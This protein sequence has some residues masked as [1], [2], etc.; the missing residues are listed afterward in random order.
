MSNA[1][2]PHDDCPVPQIEAIGDLDVSCLV[3]D[4]PFPCLGIPPI[5]P[6]FS[7]DF[8]CYPLDI[9]VDWD[10]KPS[11]EPD[12]SVRVS[13][14][15]KDQTGYCRPQIRFRVRMGAAGCGNIAVMVLADYNVV[16]S[17]CQTIDG[18][19]VCEDDRVITIAQTD[20][21]ENDVWVVKMGEWERYE[22]AVI[23]NTVVV[24]FGEKHG[25]ETWQI[26]N[27]TEP[28]HGVD[29]IIW[30]MTSMLNITCRY[31]TTSATMPLTGIQNPDGTNT[32]TGDMVAV[33]TGDRVAPGT[34]DGIWVANDAGPW[35]QLYTVDA[36]LAPGVTV[37]PPGTV[38]TVWDGYSAPWL[39]VV[40]NNY[41]DPGP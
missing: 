38:V 23:C 6:P 12:F 5:P 40:G 14:L 21:K 34:N 19:Y 16:L 28:E 17:G 10:P 9:N 1:F 15:N 41:L 39:Y 18:I 2:P 8:G 11:E 35:T 36:A 31:R 26:D 27:P 7:F 33:D 25:R 22:T 13:Y 4:P 30:A 20:P 37:L 24:R 29:T 3:A 32:V